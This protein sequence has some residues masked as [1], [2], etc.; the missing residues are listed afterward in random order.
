MQAVISFLTGLN[1]TAVKEYT[2]VVG[3]ILFPILASISAVLALVSGTSD[4]AVWF[5][6][7]AVV[8]SAIVGTVGKEYFA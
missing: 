7:A 6:I 4:V 3:V 2:V 5:L 8:V 1:K